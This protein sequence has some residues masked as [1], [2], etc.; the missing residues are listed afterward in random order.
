MPGARRAAG[1]RELVRLGANLEAAARN[2]LT[3]LMIGAMNGQLETV[4]ELLELGAGRV[5]TTNTHGETARDLALHCGHPTIVALLDRS[6]GWSPLHWAI[7]NRR[8][9]RRLVAL[10]RGGADPFLE[11]AVGETPLQ[12]CMLTDPLQGA[13]PEDPLLTEALQQ[14]LRPWHRNRHQFF[15]HSFTRRIVTVLLLQR[16]LQRQRQRQRQCPARHAVWLSEGEW[17]AVVPFLPRFE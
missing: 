13:L 15:P 1:I 5:A 14:A 10:L 12:L 11:S 17:L 9:V 2:G 16:R 4:R 7:T 8:G 3:A 6:L